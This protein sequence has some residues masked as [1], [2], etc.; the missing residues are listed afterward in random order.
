[1]QYKKRMSFW[2]NLFKATHKSAIYRLFVVM[3]RF[4]LNDMP[5]SHFDL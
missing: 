1:M 3:K 2:K 4:L 5:Y